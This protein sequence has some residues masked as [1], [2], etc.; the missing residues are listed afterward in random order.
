MGE[1][2]SDKPFVCNLCGWVN[3]PLKLGDGY[4]GLDAYLCFY[5]DMM[6]IK[7]HMD[8]HLFDDIRAGRV[9]YTKRPGEWESVSTENVED[10]G[11]VTYSHYYVNK[12]TGE[13]V[14]D[15]FHYV[16]TG[17]GVPYDGKPS[18]GQARLINIGVTG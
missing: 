6:F 10:D 12:E 4:K 15:L 17:E 2:M 11:E 18:K 13:K 1:Q 8:D 9:A 3:E 16:E 14:H 7:Q 5:G